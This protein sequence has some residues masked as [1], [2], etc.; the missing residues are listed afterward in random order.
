MDYQKVYNALISKRKEFLLKKSKDLYTELHHI[1]PRCLGGA[2]D[3]ENLVRLT[4]R[5]HFIAHRLLAK[6]HK[7]NSDLAL[8]VL[9]MVSNLKGVKIVS[10]RQ[11]EKLREEISS[12]TKSRWT[13]ELKIKASERMSGQR[14]FCFGKYGEEHPAFGHKKSV[15]FKGM[16]S[17]LFHEY[18]TNPSNRT[19]ILERVRS[20]WDNPA[21]RKLASERMK[22]SKNHNYGKNVSGRLT[23][24]QLDLRNRR[25][26]EGH[27][28]RFPPEHYSIDSRKHEF[29]EKADLL[30]FYLNLNDYRLTADMLVKV[31][32]RKDAEAWNAVETIRCRVESGWEPL[33]DPR[34]VSYT[35]ERASLKPR[36]KVSTERLVSSPIKLS[37]KKLW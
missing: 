22:G 15:E 2:D 31:Y 8:A 6:I 35:E 21:N 36:G 3:K 7:Y 37:S 1:V 32:G 29:W 34:W 17:E 18:W 16:V 10:S 14:N 9:L 12:A 28:K 26:S 33:E 11:I 23:R 20:F 30:A 19:L 13:S 4:A 24:E 25:V 5:E 27:K